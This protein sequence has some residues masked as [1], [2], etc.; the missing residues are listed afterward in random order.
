M[1]TV[2]P[3]VDIKSKR[4]HMFFGMRDASMT[5]CRVHHRIFW[6]YGPS[7]IAKPQNWSLRSPWWRRCSCPPSEWTGAALRE[8]ARVPHIDETTAL[9]TLKACERICPVLYSMPAG[10]G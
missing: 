8:A 1:P 3:Q 2:R 10:R 6:P 5:L 7:V 9:L 4:P